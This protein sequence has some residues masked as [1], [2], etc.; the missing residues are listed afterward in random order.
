MLRGCGA[1]EVQSQAVRGELLLLFAE[2]FGLRGS[3]WEEEA[4]GESDADGNRA[5]DL[6]V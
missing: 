6:Y 2:E 1:V 3:V 5:F 4:G